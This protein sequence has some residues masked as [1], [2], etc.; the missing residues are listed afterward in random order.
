MKPSETE[1][2]SIFWDLVGN[3]TLLYKLA[4]EEGIVD[5]ADWQEI[6]QQMEDHNMHARANDVKRKLMELTHQ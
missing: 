6:I 1:W 5:V 4:E 2:E 3:Q